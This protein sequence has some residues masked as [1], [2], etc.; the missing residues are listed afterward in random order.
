M[1]KQLTPREFAVLK[2][3]AMGYSNSQIS[4]KLFVTTNEV[5]LVIQS[6]LQKL[7]VDNHI[8]AVEKAA[9]FMQFERLV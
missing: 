6:I 9:L 1:I 4:Q 8:Q 7:N 3:L 5:E 2:F